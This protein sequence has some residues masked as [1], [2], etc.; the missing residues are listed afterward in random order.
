MLGHVGNWNPEDGSAA[1]DHQLLGVQGLRV[2]GWI[3]GHAKANNDQVNA[4]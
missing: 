4:P 2:R 1:L 3:V